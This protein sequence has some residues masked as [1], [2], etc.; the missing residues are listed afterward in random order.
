[1]VLLQLLEATTG[2]GYCRICCQRSPWCCCV[3]D[4]QLAP[5]ET[6]RQMMAR[7]PGQGV[8]ASIGGPTTPGTATAEVQE[9]GVPPL[10]PGLHP[11]DFTNWS[12]PLTEAPATGGLPTPSGGLP[13]IRRQT[14]GPWAL[15]QRAPALPMQAPSAPQGMLPV[16]QPR[17]HQPATPYQQAVQPQSQPTTP[18]EQAVQPSSQP[19][20]P[21]QQAVQPPRRP[22]G[23]G[24]LTRPTSDRAAPAANQTIPDC[25][26]QQARGQGI[27]GRS[28]SHPRRGRGMTTNAPS[29]TT[30]GDAKSQPGHRS[31]LGCPDPAEMAAKYRSSGW[32]RDLE[33][34]LKV[35]YKH[36]VQIPFR[37]SE[38]VRVRELFFDC[39]TPKKA[40][41]LIIKEESP[42]DYMPYIAEEFHRATGLRLNDLPEFTLWIKRGSYF[43][44]LLVE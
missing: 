14:V 19:A 7:M 42:L 6:W 22:A 40:E 27:R 1:M 31:Q 24:L 12:L 20:T 4:Y 38:W 29:T 23:R 10:P 33:H 35:Y 5:T 11:P 32:R 39:L 34:V 26:R 17:L 3:D 13:D 15:G 37:E 2:M 16:C 21:Y 25:G 8:A 28:V 43:H 41:A 44:G 36:T 18:Y 9:Q 30:Q